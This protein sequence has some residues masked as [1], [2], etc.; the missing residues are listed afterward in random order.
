MKAMRFLF[1]SLALT[2]PIL[3]L[4]LALVAASPF[5]G[6]M[7]SGLA[8]AGRSPWLWA[9]ALIAGALVQRPIYAVLMGLVVGGASILLSPAHDTAGFT[10]SLLLDSA[11]F[12]IAVIAALIGQ[13]VRSVAEHRRGG[14]LIRPAPLRR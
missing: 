8:V 13:I 11:R 1:L 4:I 5:A 3:A 6:A 2:P 9:A 7:L 12:D 14:V 10:G